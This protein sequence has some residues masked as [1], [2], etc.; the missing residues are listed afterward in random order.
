MNIFLHHGANLDNK[1]DNGRTPLLYAAERGKNP[2]VQELLLRGADVTAQ[3]KDGNSAV[4]LARAR[5]YHDIAALIMTA[6]NYPTM[7][8]HTS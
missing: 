2:M 5:G 1:T 8:R 7:P 4:E 3:D 6:I